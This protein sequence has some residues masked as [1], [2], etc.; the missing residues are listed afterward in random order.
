MALTFSSEAEAIKI[1]FD[2]DASKLIIE[3]TKVIAKTDELEKKFKAFSNEQ[4]KR[5]QSY[6]AVERQKADA[7]ARSAHEQDEAIRK[8]KMSWTDFRSMY[9]TVL[10]VVRV[11]QAI[12]NETGQKY[13]D[14]AILVGNLA[15]AL[16]T[17]TEEASRLKEVADDV[18][19]GVDSLRVS[20]KLALKDGFEPNIDG[21]ARMSDE[22][23]KLAPGTERMQY[24]LD[25]FGKSG[26]E[27]G[28]ILEKGGDSIREMAA[29]MDEGLI[30]T[31]EAYEEAD[32]YRIAVDQLNDSW[33]AFTYKV[34]PPL[35]RGLT[36]IINRQMDIQN[37]MEDAVKI[38]E[39]WITMT[40]KER[41][42]LI[43]K[44]AAD[45]EAADAALLAAEAAKDEGDAF[46]EIIDPLKVAEDALKALSEAN[47]AF[48]GVMGSVITENQRYGSTQGELAKGSQELLAEKQKLLDQGWSMES[49]K[50][51]DVNKKLAENQAKM[52]ENKKAH[53][54]WTDAKIG[55]LLLQKLSLDGLQNEELAYYMAYMTNSGLMSEADAQMTMDLI[56][57]AD[58]RIAAYEAEQEG[59]KD[60]DNK[61]YQLMDRYRRLL[62]LSL[63]PVNLLI[64][65]TTIGKMPNTA[66]ALAGLSTFGSGGRAKGGKL[67]EGATIVGDSPSGALTPYSE[68]IINGWVFDAKMTREMYKAGLLDDAVNHMFTGEGGFGG[69]FS[70][71]IRPS[72]TA[73][74]SGGRRKKPPG[75]ISTISI[76]STGGTA[77]AEA[78]AA[79][80]AVDV[81]QEATA[82][83]A[84]SLTAAESIS[85]NV[86]ASGQ[87]TV[88]AQYESSGQIVDALSVTNRLL[89]KLIKET[90]AQSYQQQMSI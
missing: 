13:V 59:L 72:G 78:E 68:A 43:D 19:I 62:N 53:K 46:K 17:T 33:D 40:Q 28:K 85:Q 24:L 82:V 9:Q 16:G 56:A 87:Q 69:G 37:A 27:M 5:A 34:A 8:N 36:N 20:M 74:I 61:L 70:G 63:T 86:Q 66:G 47:K 3:E 55:D 4:T 23:L 67:F 49:T 80:M 90:Q 1:L 39:N 22:Y 76:S 38:G 60:T 35:V 89:N 32:A 45:R 2:G 7:I 65:I 83:A 88:A 52:D 75:S 26:E 84:Q 6:M 30:V 31:Q 51:Q 79:A 44:A 57:G 14:N 29:A 50:V 12:W 15:R 73:Q 58:K 48:V 10:D 77:E 42:V 54:A 71:G 64:T 11:G 81:A 25:R 41:D 21:L 18:G